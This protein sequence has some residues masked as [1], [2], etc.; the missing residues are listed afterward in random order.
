MQ[1][2]T[3]IAQDNTL[4]VKVIPIN[5]EV[6]IV[7]KGYLASSGKSWENQK[8][9]GNQIMFETPSGFTILK[10]IGLNNLWSKINR[11]KNCK[12]VGPLIAR[13][14][15]SISG[16]FS[17]ICEI[18]NSRTNFHFNHYTNTN[19]ISLGRIFYTTCSNSNWEEISE[20]LISKFSQSNG[21]TPIEIYRGTGRPKT[22][23]F[24]NESLRESLS[25]ELVTLKDTDPLNC[26]GRIAL[27]LTLQINKPSRNIEPWRL[28]P[29]LFTEQVKRIISE[30]N[31]KDSRVSVPK[32]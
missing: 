16:D 15:S 3:A 25:A 17:F 20:S 27:R 9:I 1:S 28:G 29:L 8:K 4:S 12:Y 5:P 23:T 21:T 19:F 31:T 14:S 24:N 30:T 22:I 7:D 13:D 18:E 6:T 2:F 26:P 32:F 10:D 11:D